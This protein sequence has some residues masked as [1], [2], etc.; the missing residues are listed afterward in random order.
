MIN[1][2]D[3]VNPITTLSRLYLVF[4]RKPGKRGPAE[5]CAGGEVGGAL[6]WNGAAAQRG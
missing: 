2:S 3:R 1:L 4:E 5:M 6:A